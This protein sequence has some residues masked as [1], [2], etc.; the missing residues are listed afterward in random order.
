MI[1]VLIAIVLILLCVIILI[2]YT[3]RKQ[4]QKLRF[5]TDQSNRTYQEQLK[6]AKTEADEKLSSLRDENQSL[7]SSIASLQIKTDDTTRQ[8]AER[9]ANSQTIERYKKIYEDYSKKLRSQYIEQ[10]NKVNIEHKILLEQLKQ[11]YETEQDRL[12]RIAD[13]AGMDA[14]ALQQENK[15]LRAQIKQQNAFLDASRSNLTAIPYM[16][17]LIADYETYGIEH[18]A[19]CL[20]WGYDKKRQKKVKDIRAIR[21]DAK[22]LLEQHKIAEYQLAYLLNL[23]PALQEVLDY[24]YHSLP[25]VQL[26]ELE[27]RDPVH[28]YLSN[29]EYGRLSTTERNQLALDRYIESSKTKWQIGRD[30]ETYIG[31]EYK[32]ENAFVDFFGQN[33]GLSDLGRDLI[34]KKMDQT[35]L[36]VQCKYWSTTKV[37]HEKHITQLFGTMISYCIENAYQKDLVTG[38]LVTN[39]V[40]SD[41]AKKM[42]DYLGI[43]YREHVPMGN[44]PRIKCNNGH[45]E[46]GKPTK[47][48]H[49]PFDQQYD[50]VTMTHPGDMWTYTV[51]EAEDAGFR[52]A[53]RWFGAQN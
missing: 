12:K 51:K 38:V 34:V 48:Y 28:D 15:G 36:I 41:T 23:Y 50:H 47:I 4:L 22:E 44:F 5:E 13:N 19:Q 1:Y 18:L 2:V 33:K 31:H 3:H 40:L 24:E 16:A 25:I 52:R 10:L 11:D 42:A 29:E 14:F 9:D 6:N 53:K 39:T 8:L 49:L 35:V 43:Q 27:D 17:A 46:N 37:I 32:K 20:D 30:Y 7:R 26:S 45:D 21:K